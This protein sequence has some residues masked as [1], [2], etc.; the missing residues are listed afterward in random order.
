MILI[1]VLYQNASASRIPEPSQQGLISSIIYFS[2]HANFFL[3]LFLDQS[4][5]IVSSEDRST[6]FKCS[7]CPSVFTQKGNLTRHIKNIHEESID[8]NKKMS[9]EAAS[10]MTDSEEKTT[11]FKCSVC[12]SVF[13]KKGNLTRHTAA[14]HEQSIQSTLFVYQMLQKNCP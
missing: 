9:L 7:K 4:Q 5:D 11:I 6:D 2:S 12:P 8:N 1:S 3:T 13:T 14:T 10:P